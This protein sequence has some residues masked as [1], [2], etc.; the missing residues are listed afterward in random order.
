MGRFMNG[1]TFLGFDKAAQAFAWRIKDPG[2]DS[3]QEADAALALFEYICDAG[4]SGPRHAV[5]RLMDENSKVVAAWMSLGTN[6]DVAIKVQANRTLWIPAHSLE[7]GLE[8]DRGWRRLVNS[9]AGNKTPIQWHVA[10]A[11]QIIRGVFKFD[12]QSLN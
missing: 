6:D 8:A 9:N 11:D 3:R 4:G 1:G 2:Y 12:G 7:Q 5:V 10:S